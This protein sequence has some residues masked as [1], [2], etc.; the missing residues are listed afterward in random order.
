MLDIRTVVNGNPQ[1]TSRNL[2]CCTRISSSINVGTS[3]NLP[4]YNFHT[5]FTVDSFLLC[6]GSVRFVQSSIYLVILQFDIAIM[7]HLS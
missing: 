1:N 5:Y 2:Y 7:S 4:S 3:E 6:F